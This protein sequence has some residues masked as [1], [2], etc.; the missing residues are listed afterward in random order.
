[1]TDDRRFPFEYAIIRVVPSLE[2]GE[3]INAGVI[4]HSRPARF[5][6]CRT[7]LDRARLAAIAPGTDPADVEAHLSAIDR[8]AEGDPD[9]GPIAH[10]SAPE[11]FH[12]LVSPAST[13]VQPSRIHTGLTADPARMLEHLFRALVLPVGSTLEAGAAG[14]QDVERREDR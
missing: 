12:W 5:L 11:R 3:R 4:V 2:R 8:I 10:L 7:Q 6:G 1:M 9:A 14:R 13:I